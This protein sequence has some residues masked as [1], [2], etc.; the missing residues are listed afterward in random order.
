[1]GEL[2]QINIKNLTYYFYNDII[3]LA[4]FDGSKIKVDKK[5][6]NDIDIYYL[7]YEYKKK[8]TGCN[9]TNSVNPLYFR[10]TDMKGQF[11][12]GKSDNVWYLKIFGD[13]DV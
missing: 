12:K 4:E 7:D 6:F 9:E 1:M 13:V 2:K 3:D 8:I 5:D 11:K 10:I